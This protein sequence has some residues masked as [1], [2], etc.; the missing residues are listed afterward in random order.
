MHLETVLSGQLQPLVSL[1]NS[2]NS[3]HLAAGSDCFEGCNLS[4]YAVYG[5]AL[6]A[7]PTAPKQA[8]ILILLIALLLLLLQASCHCR[9]TMRGCTAG[10]WRDVAGQGGNA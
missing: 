6:V 7:F 10:P 4:A 1:H 3:A 5:T 2:N 9:L 8:C